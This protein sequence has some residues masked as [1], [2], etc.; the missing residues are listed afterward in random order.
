MKIYHF[1]LIFGAVFLD[2]MCMYLYFSQNPTLSQ[3]FRD[4]LDIVAILTLQYCKS[5]MASACYLEGR[6]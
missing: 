2:N 5:F 3:F 1:W 6:V 4:I